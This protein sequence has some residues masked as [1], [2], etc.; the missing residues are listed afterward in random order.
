M[1]AMSSA[2]ALATSEGVWERAADASSLLAAALRYAGSDGD[3]RAGCG[4][5]HRPPMRLGRKAGNIRMKQVYFHTCVVVRSF[6][7]TRARLIVASTWWP[8]PRR[9]FRAQR[10]HVSAV[11]CCY[12]RQDLEDKCEQNGPLHATRR[13]RRNRGAPAAQWTTHS[14]RKA[15]E[16]LSW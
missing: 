6:G 15:S 4:G 1:T 9:P 8:Q 12:A 14:A 3:R 5:G 11:L 7:D 10:Q 2:T 16:P 13:V